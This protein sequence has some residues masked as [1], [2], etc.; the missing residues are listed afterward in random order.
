MNKERKGQKL[1]FIAHTDNLRGG[2]E[3]SLVELIKSAKRR[4]YKLHVVAPGPGEFVEKIEEVG[5]R[6]TPIR[7][8][9]WGRAF[10]ANESA[11][12]LVAFKKITELIKEHKI[13]CVITNT[14]MVPWGA[15]AAAVT[16]KPHIWIT[17]E[18]LTH[19]H[20]HLHENYDF[21][22]AY[23]NLVFANSKDNANYLQKQIGMKNVRQFYSFVDAL[24]LR[25]NSEQSKP[26][27]VYIAARI[28][29]DKDQF[30]L[31]KALKIL[32]NRNQLETET[33]LIGGYKEED[34]YFQEISSFAKKNNLAEKIEFVGY[35]PNPFELVGPND[36]FVRTSKHESLGRAITE[37]MKLGL[38]VVAADI[39]SS[40][41]AFKLGGGSLYKSGDANDLAKTLEKVIDNYRAFK[42]RAMEAQQKALK[43]LSEEASHQ[44]F[45]E[46]LSKV[47][48]QI[49]PRCELK[50]IYPQFSGVS[51]TLEE[52]EALLNHYKTLSEQRKQ[53]I[54]DITNSKGW[55]TVLFARKVLRR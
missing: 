3:L 25:L 17:R 14:L 11:A 42:H 33:L 1:L 10:S 35:N 19:H 41:E 46:E 54:A 27:I 4:G 15:L 18:K 51:E 47:S 45:F 50:S 44:L 2:G 5:A 53:T 29:P 32:Q 13:D 26:R 24:D 52:R 36:I 16:N 40:V 37:A 31:I 22:E 34:E 12:N 39:P 48:G 23:S 9:Y 7:Y 43:N 49:N 30:E 21:I 20:S 55:K 6:C 38:I 8:Y 28:H